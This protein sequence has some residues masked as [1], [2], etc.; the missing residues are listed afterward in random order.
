MARKTRLHLRAAAAAATAAAV[1]GTAVWMLV[2][3]RGR[4][5]AWLLALLCVFAVALRGYALEWRR[6]RDGERPQ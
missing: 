5:W 3:R 2:T 4:M 1:L 6:L